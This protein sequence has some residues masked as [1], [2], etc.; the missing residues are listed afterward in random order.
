MQ[1]VMI[2]GQPGS[3]KSTLARKLGEQ[4]GLPV[5]HIDTIHWQPGWVERS[6]DE[7]TRLCR[8]VEARERWI[9][10]GGAFD[11]VEQPSGPRRYVDMDRSVGGASLLARVLQ[12]DAQP[13]SFT[14]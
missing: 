7:K 8:E 1:R 2:V 5:V 14:A 4:T 13:R 12:N 11:H 6:P 10:E 3:G 9:F